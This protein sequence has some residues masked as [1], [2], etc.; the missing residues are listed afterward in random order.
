[1]ALSPLSLTPRETHGHCGRGA[2][3]CWGRDSAPG[4]AGLDGCTCPQGPL[5]SELLTVKKAAMEHQ[6]RNMGQQSSEKTQSQGRQKEGGR[7]LR[8]PSGPAVVSQGQARGRLNFCKGT[9]YDK[10]KVH[11]LT[12][13]CRGETGLPQRSFK[14]EAAVFHNK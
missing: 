12:A 10:P 9:D 6:R 3:G 11:E 2:G 4:G 7:V 8:T 14:P 13:I 1:M 5:F